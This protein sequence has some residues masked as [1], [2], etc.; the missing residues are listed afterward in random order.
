SYF[1]WVQNNYGY[2]WSEEE[3]NNKL[4]LLM[5]KAF[6]N[7]ILTAEKKHTSLRTAALMIAIKRVALA[8]KLRG[9]YP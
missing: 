3:I 7:V 8:A 5:A 4:E 2:Y 9:I 1:E 6:S